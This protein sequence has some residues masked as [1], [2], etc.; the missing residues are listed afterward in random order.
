MRVLDRVTRAVCVVAGAEVAGAEVA[1]AEVAGAEVAGA[2]VAQVQSPSRSLWAGERMVEDF[3][4]MH[5]R[6]QLF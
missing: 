3:L 5:S 2:E 6:G 1:G 4:P